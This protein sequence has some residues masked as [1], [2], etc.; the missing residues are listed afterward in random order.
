MTA[1]SE[2]QE[3]GLSVVKAIEKGS[4][5][6]RIMKIW[7]SLDVR[8]RGS[9]LGCGMTWVPE[10]NLPISIPTSAYDCL[11]AEECTELFQDLLQT[12]MPAVKVFIRVIDEQDDDF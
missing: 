11:T 4:V 6:L 8:H 9:N 12:L 3:I 7:G 2:E 1:T 5:R 10:G